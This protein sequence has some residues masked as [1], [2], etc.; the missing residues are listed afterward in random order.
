METYLF[1]AYLKYSKENNQ[2]FWP[3]L[4]SRPANVIVFFVLTI[5]S[6]ICGLIFSLCQWHIASTISI[7]FEILFT[8]IFYFVSEKY[9]IDFSTAKY[10]D[11]KSYC[12]KLYDWIKEF[13]IGTVD[14]V[15]ALYQN[16]VAKKQQLE[17]EEENKNS[18]GERWLQ[19]LIIPVII[20]IIT[21][22]SSRQENM[23]EMIVSTFLIISMFIVVYGA[24][25]AIR[26]IINF[27]Q[28]RKI[29][30]MECF[31]TDL[32]ALLSIIKQ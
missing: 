29:K 5:I 30:Q 3:K 19:T 6:S 2:S 4:I 12:L 8:T 14:R 7:S 25:S 17:L 11:Y 21:T 31:A 24:I 27:P 10:E 22:A 1:Y 32:N 16:V 28:K 13:D 15:E 9:R 26:S 18:R 20:A 23:S